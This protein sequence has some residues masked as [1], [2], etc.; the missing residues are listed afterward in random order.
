MCVWRVL[1]PKRKS[2]YKAPPRIKIGKCWYVKDRDGK[3]II[4][5]SWDSGNGYFFPTH[6]K[7]TEEF[8]QNRKR[9]TFTKD[10]DTAIYQFRDWEKKQQG[11]DYSSIPKDQ[12]KKS[13][14]VKIPY[15]FLKE[16]GESV[17][18]YKKRLTE[19]NLSLRQDTGK[20]DIQI[21]PL[22]DI[23]NSFIYS[24]ARELIL[25]NQTEAAKL[26]NLP[27]LADADLISSKPS[28]TL[29]EIGNK[30]FNRKRKPLKKKN[31]EDAQNWWS[32]FCKIVGVK[33]V[34][35]ITLKHI[36]IYQDA[37]YKICEENNFSPTWLRHRF[38]M[39][40][41]IL[42]N[43]NKSEESKKD[44]NMVLEHCKNFDYKKKVDV[45]PKPIPK[46]EYNNLLNVAN[47]K[48][49]AIYLL[50][51]N[52]S[53]LPKDIHDIK[54]SDIDLSKYE[55][56]MKREKT[57]IYRVA[58]LW[59]RTVVAIQEM[60]KKYPNDSEYLFVTMKGTPYAEQTIR[61]HHKKFCKLVS[62]DYKEIHFQHIRD[63][64]ESIA[65]EAAADNLCS[66]QAIKYLMGHKLSGVSDHYRKRLP[67]LVKKAC[68][69]IESHYFDD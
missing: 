63:A 3:P 48:F 62:I 17:E 66:E 15:T 45:E 10:Y 12:L 20:S 67:K 58:W 21:E 7:L 1:M 56:K 16:D 25:Q 43:A 36:N 61:Y 49:K 39:I 42:R 23:P 51:L 30:Y 50:S 37:L 65:A 18:A 31:K 64:T 35:E 41:T 26:M 57:G 29:V 59:E 2:K 8:K 32:E 14:R 28:R 6:F 52:A 5:L 68:E 9:P 4:G 11:E 22:A 34:R 60:L 19:Y 13:D 54:K 46:L 24:K 55:L 27:G 44:I 53:M 38:D 69:Y 33:V 47:V 40:K